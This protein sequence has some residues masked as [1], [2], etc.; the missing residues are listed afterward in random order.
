MIS[1]NDFFDRTYDPVT[2]H[3][4]HFT[5]DVWAYVTGKDISDDI[6]TVL[7]PDNL[8]F[9]RRDSII[10]FS[11]YR[12]PVDPSMCVMSKLRY[13]THAGVYI[14]GRVI[15]LTRL[16]VQYQLLSVVSRGYSKV[17]FYT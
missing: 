16:G 11:A 12:C 8:R 9:V 14:D 1:L 15:H 13:G 3:C 7:L 10:K 17:R 4:G 6:Q 2:Y 5:R